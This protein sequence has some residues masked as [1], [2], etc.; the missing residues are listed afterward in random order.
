VKQGF[1]FLFAGMLALTGC[2]TVID[3]QPT[4]NPHKV[5]VDGLVT[6]DPG[7]YYVNLLYTTNYSFSDST[8]LTELISGAQVAIKDDLGHSEQLREIIPGRYRTDSLSAFRGVAGRSYS[9]DIVTET[10]MHYVSTPEKMPARVPIDSVY[11][12]LAHPIEGGE[13]FELY[14]DYIDP[15]GK[16]NYYRWHSTVNGF[17][18]IDIDIDNDQFTDG[19]T[20]NGR[21]LFGFQFFSNNES[22]PKI[23][24]MVVE[25]NQASLT[26]EAFDFWTV[27]QQ[28]YNQ[29]DNAPYDIPPSPL[30]GNIYNADDPND[31]A[32]GYFGASGF[33]TV[34]V[35]I[36]K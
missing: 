8:D 27:A 21:R 36:R 30:I 32:L 2:E 19:Q 28:H 10:G 29:Q 23:D 5:V 34:R 31:F 11:Y 25:V 17:Y 16:G 15:V 1:I 14:I 33:S 26:K 35:V 4:S 9:I 13:S 3:L 6:T 18:L 22:V 20:I 7:P 12:F 24:S